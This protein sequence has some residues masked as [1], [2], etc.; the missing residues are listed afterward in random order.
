MI[1][2][3]RAVAYI[4]EFRSIF[5]LVPMIVI[6][7]SSGYTEIRS[8]FEPLYPEFQ[9]YTVEPTRSVHF[10]TLSTAQKNQIP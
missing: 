5:L 8:R 3:R 4:K 7:I 1:I 10:Y 6:K 2:T 9:S